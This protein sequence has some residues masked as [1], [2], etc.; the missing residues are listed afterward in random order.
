[1]KVVRYFVV[2]TITNATNSTRS[3]LYFLDP[4]IG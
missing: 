2:L 3:C 4:D 1:M